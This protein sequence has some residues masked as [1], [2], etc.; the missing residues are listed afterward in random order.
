VSEFDT[1][2]IGFFNCH[3]AARFLGDAGVSHE[4]EVHVHLFVGS[5]FY[6]RFHEED[7]QFHQRA[8]DTPLNRLVSTF[9]LIFRACMLNA[10][11]DADC[12]QQ[13]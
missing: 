3:A 4:T 10:W 2:A 5:H 12:K 7:L 9:V 1:H 13:I 6:G 8:G 11:R